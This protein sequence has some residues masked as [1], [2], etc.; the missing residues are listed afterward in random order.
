MKSI[1]RFS[2]IILAYNLTKKRT[3][4][5]GGSAVEEMVPAGVK[6]W[7]WVVWVTKVAGAPE[8]ARTEPVVRVVLAVEDGVPEKVGAT[9]AE[10]VG[11]DQSE[12][13][14]LR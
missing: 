2:V 1:T 9:A 3:A 8:P 11:V 5:E 10:G 13:P 4:R 7:A 12:E 14:P 6:L